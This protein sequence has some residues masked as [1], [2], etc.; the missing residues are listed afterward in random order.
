[1]E[2]LIHPTASRH[3]NT[4]IKDLLTAQL[5][6]IIGQTKETLSFLKW[7][8]KNL[9]VDRGIRLHFEGHKA[10]E[11]LYQDMHPEQIWL[12]GSQIGATY[13]AIAR[14][15]YIACEMKKDSIYYLPDQNFARTFL[16]TRVN[17]IRD[18]SEYLSSIFQSTQY[19]GLLEADGIYCYFRGLKTIS[20]AISIPSHVNIYDEVD[21]I[22]RDNMEWS[23]DRLAASDIAWQLFLSVGMIPGAGIDAK[24]TKSD[25]HL[26]IV[27]CPGCN[28]DHVLEEEFPDNIHE[29]SDGSVI[30]VCKKCG[31]ELDR[32]AG[33]WIPKQPSESVRGYRISQLAVAR[34][35]LSRIW[36]KY[37]KV[38]D[39]NSRLAKFRCSVLAMPDA[40]NMQPITDQVLALC[41]N[42]GGGIIHLEDTARRSFAGIDIGNM[43][44]FVIVDRLPDR[45]IRILWIES[46]PSELM[47]ETSN[48]L[49]KTYNVITGC[50]DAMPYK[51]EMKKIW[52]AHQE[53]FYLR[54]YSLDPEIK[55]GIEETPIGE[56]VKKVSRDRNLALDDITD[57]MIAGRLIIPTARYGEKNKIQEF[58]E[59][60]KMLVKKEKV[61]RHGN[62]K[63]EYRKDVDNH[64]GMALANAYI[65]MQIHDQGYTGPTIPPIFIDAL[66]R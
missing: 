26:W 11:R 20:S 15:F 24:F 45:R 4:R 60:M 57:M 30:I 9:F 61:D 6:S 49:V 33:A 2:R 35:S 23:E 46:C 22:P 53:N 3:N 58:D 31:K 32:Q 16:K 7:S 13:C 5:P 42:P 21:V 50:G 63:H 28:S 54:Y 25:Q 48:R 65:A 64:Y 36:K 44:H 55:T 56:E 59:H 40:G 27:R 10:L 51:T 18:N 39:V 41:R 17:P 43:S 52:K 12:K 37:K 66:A 14:A 29:F 38:R 34:M 47:L 8:K 62:E 19:Q 1:M